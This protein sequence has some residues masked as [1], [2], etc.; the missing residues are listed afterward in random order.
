M[1]LNLFG[2]NFKVARP[3]N[4]GAPFVWLDN[5]M[6]NGIPKELLGKFKYAYVENYLDSTFD[7]AYM[8]YNSPSQTSPLDSVVTSSFRDS[9]LFKFHQRVFNEKLKVYSSE[10]SF[11]IPE[12]SFLKIL[13][14]VSHHYETKYKVDGTSVS[15]ECFHGESTFIRVTK[16]NDQFIVQ[17]YFTTDSE[18]SKFIDD[19]I[20]VLKTPPHISWVTHMSQEGLEI[21]RIPLDPPELIDNSFYPWLKGI[22]L[23]DYIDSYIN[24]SESILLLFGQP[25][26]GKSNLLKY[27]LH[28]TQESALITY[29]DN[30]RDLDVMFS[31]F[32][33]GNEKYLIIE[34]ADEFLVKR[35]QGNTAMKRLLNV[36]DGLTSNRNKKVIFTTNLTSTSSIDPALLREGRCYDQVYFSAYS[37]EEA[38]AVASILEIPEESLVN[39]KYTLAE[40]FAIKTARS[41]IR[42][43]QGKELKFGFNVQ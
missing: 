12:E 1:Y 11:N 2:K 31:S 34:D 24:S 38:L 39:E 4:L 25:G 6:K 33:K 20:I 18:F 37:K 14:K 5:E 3:V 27:L 32:L 22:D 19:E 40:L 21:D 36:T 23:K 30:I 17:N 13:N 8:T 43:V 28:Y 35:E 7:T 41:K 29:Q 15:Y 42:N 16:E 10:A 9:F 26:T